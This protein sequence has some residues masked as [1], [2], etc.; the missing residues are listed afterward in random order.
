MARPYNKEQTYE[1]QKP[2][3]KNEEQDAD[4][5]F[6]HTPIDFFGFGKATQ[7]TRRDLEAG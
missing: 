7:F 2:T 6:D 3:C 1:R 5:Y 4:F